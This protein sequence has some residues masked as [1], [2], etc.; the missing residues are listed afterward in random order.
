M[1]KTYQMNFWSGEFGINYTLRKDMSLEE[2]DKLYINN[3]GISRTDLNTEFLSFLDK[4]IRILEVGTNVGLQLLNLQRMGFKDL[5]GIEIMDYA[6]ELAKKRTKNINLVT[7]SVLNIPFKDSFFDMVFTSRVLIHVHPK[8]L[9]K[10]I[11]E[12]YRTSREYIWC[13]EYF[14]DTCQEINYR[15]NKNVLWKNNFMKIFLERHPDLEVVK[16]KKFKYK[17]N[18]NVD[19]MFLLRKSFV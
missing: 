8:D 12:I 14:S 10:A 11:D 19:M 4:K 7:A 6:V 17:N 3:F 5:L 9:P 15:G 13:F 2:L 1:E 18:N 16:E